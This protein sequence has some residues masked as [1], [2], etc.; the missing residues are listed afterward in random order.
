MESDETGTQSVLSVIVFKYLC[1][2][3]T[4]DSAKEIQVS[5][6]LA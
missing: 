5:L 4:A 6:L 1:R 3:P 2:F